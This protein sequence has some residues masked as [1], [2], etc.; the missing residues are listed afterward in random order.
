MAEV[1]MPLLCHGETTDPAADMFDRE[2]LWVSSVL[3]PL[4]QGV[5][6]LKVVME[7]CTTAEG[8]EFVMNAREGV[9]ATITVQHLLLN[10]NALFSYKGQVRFPLWPLLASFDGRIS[11]ILTPRRVQ[12]GL[13][14]HH[15]CL[16]ILKRE[17]HRAALVKAA[18]SGSAKFFAG[19]D[20]APHT[21]DKKE[22]SCGC[23]GCFTAASALEVRFHSNAQ[24]EASPTC[25]G[26]WRTRVGFCSLPNTA[27]AHCHIHT[28]KR[29]FT[30]ARFDSHDFCR[31]Q[32]SIF[33]DIGA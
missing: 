25:E 18:T 6:E 10:R 16:P 29:S 22:T 33:D 28:P 19:T 26:G 21:A 20:S 14:P 32:I 2:A 30:G 3:K 17:K 4:V 5:P 12:G 23:A 9:A 27:V 15:Y 1:G 24:M 8:V 7:H 31:F 11:C 13:R